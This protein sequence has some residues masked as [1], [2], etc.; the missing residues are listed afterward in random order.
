MRPE[1]AWS[2]ER[3]VPRELDPGR[4]VRGI[5][6]DTA[7]QKHATADLRIYSLALQ[8]HALNAYFLPSGNRLHMTFSVKDETRIL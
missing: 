6:Q 8:I 1:E 5:G 2:R 3:V 7:S 4:S